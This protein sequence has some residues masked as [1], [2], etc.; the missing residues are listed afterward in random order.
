MT[1]FWWVGRSW[2]PTASDA[3]PGG[4]LSPWGTV[5]TDRRTPHKEDPAIDRITITG[6]TAT[7]H[8]GVFPQERR[9]G[10]LFVVD[11]ELQ[12]TLDTSSDDLSRTVSYAE[13]ADHVVDVITGEPCNLIETVAG[14]VADRCLAFA[15][16]TGVVV[17]V[18]KPQAPVPHTFTDLSV[19][20]HRSRHD[21]R[22]L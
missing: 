3:P 5:A 6:V 8:H 2:P 9:D 15:P 17:T 19:T 22:P 11:V 20:I 1:R 12:L 21:Q 18:H 7:G 14:R 4:H 10:Q 13:V 16:V